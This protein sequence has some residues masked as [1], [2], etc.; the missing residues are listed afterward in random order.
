MY[1]PRPVI[2]EMKWYT[3][4]LSVDEVQEP[5]CCSRCNYCVK[6]IADDETVHMLKDRSYCS[7][8]CRAKGRSALYRSLRD[9][10]S[11]MS[12]KSTD[13]TLSCSHGAASVVCAS[14][15]DGAL[16]R[17]TEKIIL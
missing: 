10:Q 12:Q 15:S 6:L 3:H 14:H 1:Y 5:D 4:D 16:H 13:S 9:A 2:R 7:T 8:T 11:N 17:A